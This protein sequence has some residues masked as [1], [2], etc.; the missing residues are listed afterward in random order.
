MTKVAKPRLSRSVPQQAVLDEIKR[1]RQEL[2]DMGD[3]LLILE[4]RVRD[5]GKPGISLEETRK[6]LGLK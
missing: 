4:A 1:L 3:Y 2:D 5:E 6:R